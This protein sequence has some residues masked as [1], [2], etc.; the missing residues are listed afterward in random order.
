MWLTKCNIFVYNVFTGYPKVVNILRGHIIPVNDC[1]RKK[2]ESS[3]SQIYERLQSKEVLP[4]LYSWKVISLAEV[5][6]IKSVAN[7]ESTQ[8][9]ALELILALPNRSREWYRYFI[10]A[11]IQ[12]RQTELAE[13]V[14]KDLAERLKE[15]M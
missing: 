10:R 2:I 1:N 9:A 6:K 5:E 11:L 12:T 3:V 15:G 7:T 8:N 14:D 4:Y 13:I